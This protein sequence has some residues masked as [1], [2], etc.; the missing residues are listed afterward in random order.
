MS[1]TVSFTS[2]SKRENST[3]QLTMTGTHDCVLK[4]G[5]SMLSPTL[6]LELST[7]TF[8]DFTAFKIDDRYYKVS[9]IRSVRNNLF[10]ISGEVDVLATYKAN[11]LATTAYVLYD[12]VS[13]NELPDNRLPIKTTKSVQSS[14]AP[15]PMTPASGRY[16][17]SITGHN[18]TGVYLMDSGELNG[19][20][21]DV[22]NVAN[23]FW[24]NAP[25]APSKP[26]T[27]DLWDWLEYIG[28]I[29]EWIWECFKYPITQFFGTKSIPDNIRGCTYIPFNI[30]T[31]TGARDVWLGMFKLANQYSMLNTETVHLTQSVSI[32]WQ[33][34]DWRR[35]SP[36]TDVYLYIPYIGMTKL[37]SENLAGQS[38]VTVNYDIA[39]RDGSLICTV[40]SGSEILGQYPG[41]IGA[42]VPIGV[43]S[44]NL[45]KAAQSLI[46][47]IASYAKDKIA[48]T[49]MAALSFGDSVTPNFSCVGGL[50]GIAGIATNQN[51]TC[52]TVLHDTIVAPNT[53][54][55][56]IGSPT[57]SP[58]SLA[59]LTGF[60]QTMSASVD[61]AM[62][63]D[64]RTKIN[65]LLNNGIFI[66]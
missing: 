32:P 55:Q 37:S 10:E 49:G 12:S 19:L 51:I 40:T 22:S 42:S 1:I 46:T 6:L 43:A 4:N 39:L 36:Y 53:E 27:H 47:G 16:I 59:N 60:V 44:Y 66:E 63:T 7:N 24:Q 8:P 3:K 57:M 38:S 20:I 13:N 62:T 56:T 29:F 25:S 31:S 61:G 15:A 30:G 17:V 58:K 21:E 45:P 14:T 64:E 41:N 52:Y 50:D 26:G 65:D 2:S 28:D 34:N 35:R 54:L 5:C 18:S 48:T 33:T 23:N 9:D 11:I